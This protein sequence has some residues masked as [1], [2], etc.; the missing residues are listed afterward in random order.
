MLV[1][2]VGNMACCL[3]RTTI[4]SISTP[5]RR[6]S[7]TKK[8]CLS[9]QWEAGAFAWYHFARDAQAYRARP[10]RGIPSP[11]GAQP[12]ELI[13]AGFSP[14]AYFIDVS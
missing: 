9:G 1:K 3:P 7:A 2:I 6:A 13:R 11:R 14:T 5:T 12:Q 8:R 4:T 10:D